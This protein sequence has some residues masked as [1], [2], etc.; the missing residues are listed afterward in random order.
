MK[1]LNYHYW[2]ML[3]SQL[4]SPLVEVPIYSWIVYSDFYCT[5]AMT[6]Q[7]LKT[8]NCCTTR[9]GQRSINWDLKPQNFHRVTN[10]SCNQN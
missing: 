8:V 1:I 6:K 10:V 5:L 2:Q 9:A 4:A 3:V 7:G